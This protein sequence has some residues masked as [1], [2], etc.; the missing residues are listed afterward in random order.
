MKINFVFQVCDV[1]VCCCDFLR[2]EIAVV[3]T[4][5]VC[6]LQI[7]VVRTDTVCLL[8]IAV[9]RTDTVCLL[10]IAVVRTDTVCLLQT[11]VNPTVQIGSICTQN[12]QRHSLW[13]LEMICCMDRV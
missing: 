4:D 8:Q 7:A 13:R 12:K 9:V 5:T 10:Q 11:T 1:T 3:R 2:E 6:L